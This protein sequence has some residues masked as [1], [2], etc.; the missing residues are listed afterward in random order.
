ML[1]VGRMHTLAND[2]PNIGHFGIA[3]GLVAVGVSKAYIDDPGYVDD[4]SIRNMLPATAL[5]DKV[6]F[7]EVVESFARENLK[8][9][10]AR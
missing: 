5:I 6:R 1:I 9:K 8:G 3:R 4:F 10:L 7:G 2:L